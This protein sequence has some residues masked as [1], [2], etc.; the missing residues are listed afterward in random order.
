MSWRRVL[1]AL[2]L[3]GMVRAGHHFIRL[4]ILLALGL[5]GMYMLHMLAQD[6][7]KITN[8]PARPAVAAATRALTRAIGK[9]DV[10]A[11]LQERG[12]EQS[13]WGPMRRAV[14]HVLK[15]VL[16]QD[17]LG[18]ARKLVCQLAASKSETLRPHEAAILRL[19]ERSKL[20]DG[21]DDASAE[22]RAAQRL[23]KSSGD[24][25]RCATRYSRCLIEARTMLKLLQAVR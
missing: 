23:G 21:D 14:G 20:E 2:A 3:A 8:R 22:F 7:N 24:E 12:Q 25:A 1:A 15:Q 16:L 13:E 5:G 17:P 11:V 19:V 9:R 18:C 10:G 4:A 6:Y